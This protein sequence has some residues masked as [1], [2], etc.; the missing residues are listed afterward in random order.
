MSTQG[1]ESITP[2]VKYSVPNRY[3][4]APFG[5]ICKVISDTSESFYI[6]T[7][8][9][10]EHADWVLM[11]TVLEKAFKDYTLKAE[12]INE[13]LLLYTESKEPVGSNIRNALTKISNI[14]HQS[15]SL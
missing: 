10:K 7:S 8:N 11:G 13:C 5:T 3:E 2:I 15:L 14:I 6:Q 1:L 9:N 12:F 4:S